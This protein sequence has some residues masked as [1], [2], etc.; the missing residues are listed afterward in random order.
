MFSF[1]S[2]G[3][4]DGSHGVH[5]HRHGR[6]SFPNHGNDMVYPHRLSSPFAP[7][8]LYMYMVVPDCQSN[9]V[10]WPGTHGPLATIQTDS[11]CFGF[12][13]WVNPR[14]ILRYGACRS[15]SITCQVIK[16]LISTTVTDWHCILS[17]PQHIYREFT[18][19]LP[20]ASTADN[21]YVSN[22]QWSHASFG[23]VGGEL[24]ASERE[25][26]LVALAFTYKL[27]VH[28]CRSCPIYCHIIHHVRTDQLRVGSSLQG[29]V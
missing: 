9:R 29:A 4:E 17:D 23:W 22:V 18:L 11:H 3:S 5:L 24:T 14:S 19:A 1:L 27:Q 25:A 21:D 2:T 13:L 7:L 26:D 15:Q 8:C 16:L 20:T 6:E 12:V 28:K 10:P